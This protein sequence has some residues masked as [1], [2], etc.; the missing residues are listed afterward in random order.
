MLY[1]RQEIGNKLLDQ[2]LSTFSFPFSY[3]CEHLNVCVHMCVGKVSMHMCAHACG[4]WCWK[5][6]RVSPSSQ[7]PSLVSSASWLTLG[8]AVS[9]QGWNYR[10]A[11]TPICIYVSSGC[12]NSSSQGTRHYSL[13]R[14]YSV[15]S[16]F[17]IHK[18]N[19]V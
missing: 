7:A 8:I 2:N 9:F 14:E 17:L 11:A 3:V 1:K 12:L 19:Q 5:S 13:D 18:K 6:S 16:N 4:L 15:I 10:Q